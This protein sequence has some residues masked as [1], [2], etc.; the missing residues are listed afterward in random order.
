MD[1]KRKPFRYYRYK[2]AEWLHKAVNFITFTRTASLGYQ[3]F[4]DMN[5]VKKIAA[6]TGRSVEDYLDDAINDRQQAQKES[7][8]YTLETDGYLKR[9]IEYQKDGSVFVGFRLDMVAFKAQTVINDMN[10][11]YG[12]H[13]FENY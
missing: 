6:V 5:D 2:V 7:V 9:F 4:I 3:E 13:G 11:D 1:K 8:I 10:Y 12:K